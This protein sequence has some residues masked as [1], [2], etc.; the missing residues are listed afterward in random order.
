M[1]PQGGDTLPAMTCMA[2]W[3]LSAGQWQAPPSPNEHRDTYSN[4]GID[5]VYCAWRHGPRRPIILNTVTILHIPCLPGWLVKNRSGL[6]RGLLKWLFNGW[7]LVF[8]FWSNDHHALKTNPL[9]RAI[10]RQ[11]VHIAMVSWTVGRLFLPALSPR[12]RFNLRVPALEW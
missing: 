11:N 10:R 3:Q 5:H 2:G 1:T 8:Y 7:F 12:S 4:A 6:E 9:R